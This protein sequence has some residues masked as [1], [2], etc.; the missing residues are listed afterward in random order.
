MADAERSL[1]LDPGYAVAWSTRGNLRLLQDDW[2]SA[3]TDFDRAIELDER[4][5]MYHHG[6][7]SAWLHGN[8]PDRALPDFDRAI[9]LRDNEGSRYCRARILF[10]KGELERAEQD[11]DRAVPSGRPDVF[12]LR[13]FVRA[14]RGDRAG[15]IEDLQRFVQ[16]VGPENGDRPAA[17][18]KLSEL[19]R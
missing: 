6:R 11:L 2:R 18:A 14:A 1:E 4:E 7:G 16:M 8:E 13:G 9:E 5:G 15:A 17:L 10:G 3:V 19:K 12:R